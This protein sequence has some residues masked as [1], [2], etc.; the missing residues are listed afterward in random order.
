MAGSENRKKG[1]RPWAWLEEMEGETKT[2]D[3]LDRDVPEGWTQPLTRLDGAEGWTE[4]LARL[5]GAESWTQPLVRLDATLDPAFAK[6]PINLYYEDNHVLVVEKPAGLLSQGDVTGDPDL[7]NLLK[8]YLK[9]KYH[10]PGEA[11]LGL[12]HRLDRPVSGLMVF[13]KTSK[14]ANRLSEQVRTRKVEKEYLAVVHG[15]VPIEDKARGTEPGE[16]ELGSFLPGRPSPWVELR[17]FLSTEKQGGRYEVLEPGLADRQGARK[18]RK[19]RQAQ[20]DREDRQARNDR[21]GRQD[22]QGRA[23]GKEAILKYRVLAYFSGNEGRLDSENEPGALAKMQKAFEREQRASERQRKPFEGAPGAS[24]LTLLA[25]RLVTG[26]SH[27]IRLQMA[28]LGHPLVGDRLYGW[29]QS[30]DQAAPTVALHAYHLAFF[31]PV[32]GKKLSF[33]VP[34]PDVLPFFLF[35]KGGRN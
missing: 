7:L 21:Q 9:V 17:D 8:T 10:K 4:P 12:I 19:D 15:R 3:E 11:F 23:R 32:T 1:G 25:I 18:D 16:A 30:M 2:V 31:Q 34:P 33:Q 29:S 26:R 22:R 35:A 20:Q 27:Q 5:D 14:G 24:D 28:H 13:A 6:W